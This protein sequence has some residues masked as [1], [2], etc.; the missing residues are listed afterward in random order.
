MSVHASIYDTAGEAASHCA[1]KIL[2]LLGTS[3]ATSPHA[4]L[5]ISGGATPQ[6]MFGDLARAK[7]DWTRVHLFWV[8]ERGVP[9]TD[10]QSNYKL[11]KE[12]FIDPAGFPAANV[13]RIQ[14]ELEAREAARLYAEEIREFFSLGP[15][16]LPNF[17]IIHQGMGPDAHTASLFPGLALIDDQKNIAAAAYVEK[18]QQWRITLLPGVLRAA[19]QTVMLVA[20]E[21]K[22]EP[23]RSVLHSPYDPKRFPAQIVAAGRDNVLWFLDRA[24]ARNLI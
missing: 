10:A 18:L 1:T 14:A 17:D 22:A 12:T 8:D 15:G 21:D 3:L 24:A 19:K 16:E 7:F 6:L 2:E 5:A 9:P 20:G 11:A 13:H 23:L 4:T